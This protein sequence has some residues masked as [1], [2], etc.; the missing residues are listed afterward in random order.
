MDKEGF[1]VSKQLV[2]EDIPSGNG[3]H[4]DQTT[5]EEVVVIGAKVPAPRGG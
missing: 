5:Q 2:F 3:A 4:S 1:N